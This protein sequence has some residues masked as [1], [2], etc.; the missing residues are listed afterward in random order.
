M[1]CFTEIKSKN[2]FSSCCFSVPQDDILHCK[3]YL[4]LLLSWQ[5]RQRI[6]KE[7]GGKNSLID[8]CEIYAQKPEAVAG[9]I[10]KHRLFRT[11]SFCKI[12]IP[13]F[14]DAEKRPNKVVLRP[15]L[16]ISFYTNFEALSNGTIGLNIYSVKN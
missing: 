3:L 9:I 11:N 8:H 4:C 10:L 14:F 5:A 7:K 1:M 6:R 15:Y 13:K 12:L 2:Y 16:Q